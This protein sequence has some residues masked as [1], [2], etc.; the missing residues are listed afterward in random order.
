MEDLTLTSTKPRGRGLVFPIFSPLFHDMHQLSDTAI[1]AILSEKEW[2]STP[3]YN[4]LKTDV[5]E[6]NVAMESI[7][8]EYG[9][10]DTQRSAATM[11]GEVYQRQGPRCVRGSVEGFSGAEWPHFLGLFAEFMVE[12]NC[13]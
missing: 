2:R 10:L 8:D 3:T 11:Y 1:K 7:C 12:F 13:E 6:W 5:R 9:I 4:P